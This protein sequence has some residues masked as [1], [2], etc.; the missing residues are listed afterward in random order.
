MLYAFTTQHYVSRSIR[1]FNCLLNIHIVITLL[2]D[3]FNVLTN[4]KLK[5]HRINENTNGSYVTFSCDN[6]L[7]TFREPRLTNRQT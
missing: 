7:R 1:K 5:S 2:T 3:D 4:R 6:A